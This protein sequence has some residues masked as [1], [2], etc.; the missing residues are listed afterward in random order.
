MKSCFTGSTGCACTANT[1]GTRKFPSDSESVLLAMQPQAEAASA[2]TTSHTHTLSSGY[3][4][5]HRDLQASSTSSHTGTN[6]NVTVTP[7]SESPRAGPTGTRRGLGR[8]TRT[9]YYT[10]TLG[11]SECD[12]ESANHR[13]LEGPSRSL[14]VRP[15]ARG[16]YSS[17]P[18]ARF[19]LLELEGST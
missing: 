2:S 3:P 6:L 18:L 10:T 9:S 17:H 19:Y 11:A 4:R 1:S 12:S 13:L 14:Q 7:P 16:L 5:A 15:E 8:A